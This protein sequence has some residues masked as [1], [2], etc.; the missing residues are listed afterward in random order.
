[1]AVLS[2]LRPSA[3]AGRWYPRD[4]EQL[5]RTVDAYLAAAQTPELPGEV[6]GLVAPHAGHLYSGAT[7]GYAFACVR[8]KTIPRVVLLS[9]L[10]ALHPG[11]ISTTAHRGYETPSRGRWKLILAALE[12]LEG[13]MQAQGLAP[14]S[15]IVRDSEHS[16]EIEL[17]FLQRALA[18]DFQL[19]PLIIRT[20]NPENAARAGP[21]SGRNFERLPRRCWLPHRSLALL[22]IGSG[23][24]VR[25]RDAGTRRGIVAR[26]RAA[27]R[28]QRRR[29]GLRG[30]RGGGDVVGGP[31]RG[32]NAARVLHHSTSAEQTGDTRA[33]VGYGAAVVLKNS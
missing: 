22:L 27:G 16:L 19:I 1:M 15:R 26:R 28:S 29:P 11:E 8:G 3:I 9:P 18:G 33:V 20:H 31:G 4:A 13:S 12:A 25:C 17:P 2:E 7:A 14:L 23:C 6:V 24:P 21:G 5:A 10:H 32:A 30:G